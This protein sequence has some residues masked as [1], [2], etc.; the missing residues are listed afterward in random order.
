MEK[1]RRH[2]ICEECG[3]IVSAEIPSEI[4]I[5]ANITIECSE[6]AG[7]FHCGT[8]HL[9]NQNSKFYQEH[10][11]QERLVKLGRKQYNTNGT[12]PNG[13]PI[14][15]TEYRKPKFKNIQL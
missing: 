3:K 8:S 4:I 6:C 9:R 11:R 7:Q 13:E 15:P 14:P 1:T 5:N 10:R 2:F 12:W